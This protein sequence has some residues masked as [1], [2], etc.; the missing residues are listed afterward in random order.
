MMPY[1]NGDM[2]GSGVYALS[3]EG[4][5]RFSRF[6]DITADDQYVMQLFSRDERMSVPAATFIVHPPRALRGL[7]RMRARA[8]RGNDEL[9]R[10]GLT[11]TG[12]TGGAREALLRLTRR[13]SLWPAL[14]VY[15]MVNL[16]GK[17]QARL[18]QG[19]WE[20]DDSARSAAP[21]RLR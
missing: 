1:L 17:L 14:A 3:E 11:G 19:G 8:Y 13:P 20:R 2:V 10:C 9:A 5:G 16:G 21:R 7:V 18:Y 6:P 4:R 12:P 15:V